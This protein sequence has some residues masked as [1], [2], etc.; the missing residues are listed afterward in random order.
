MLTF[1]KISSKLLKKE[2]LIRLLNGT[3]VL[4][5]GWTAGKILPRN[6]FR[7]KRFN[8]DILRVKLNKFR[9][10]LTTTLDININLYSLEKTHK[11]TPKA[12]P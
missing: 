11:L 6:S 7:I 4:P 5:V 9:G 10:R 1:W 12:V 2:T 8:L 3:G